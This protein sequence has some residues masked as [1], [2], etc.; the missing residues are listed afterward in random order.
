MTLQQ[1]HNSSCCHQENNDLSNWCSSSIYPP[2]TSSMVV[3]KHMDSLSV[4]PSSQFS[5]QN[6]YYCVDN[7]HPVK[8]Q[9]RFPCSL[10]EDGQ[11]S[12]VADHFSKGSESIDG[13]GENNAAVSMEDT[14]RRMICMSEDNP[15]D[16]FLNGK[17]VGQSKVCARGHWKPA[18]DSKL[19]ELVALYGPQNWNL[20]AEKLQR[21]TGKSCRLRWF[22]QLD[23]RIN[24]KAFTEEEEERLMAAHRAYG[25][26]WAMIARLFPGRTD[27]AVKNHWHVIMARKYREQASAYRR[28]KLSQA[29]Q[30]KLEDNG[31]FDCSGN[32]TNSSNNPYLASSVETNGSYNKTSRKGVAAATSGRDLFLGSKRY[33][34]LSP[35]EGKHQSSLDFFSD[36]RSQEGLISRSSRQW[37]MLRDETTLTTSYPSL[38][39]MQQ[40][41]NHHQLSCFSYSIASSSQVTVTEPSS[42]PSAASTTPSPPPFIDFLGVGA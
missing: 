36:Y 38:M 22:N 4:T 25:N 23:P 27:N 1:F 20:I 40:S 3:L 12:E 24:K 19:R 28:R 34:S 39:L 2:S 6:I 7:Y 10:E 18:E 31:N 41:S 15:G 29:V 30:R 37:N 17:D 32:F 14:R 42:S 35:G 26:K 21:R 16:V 33:S 11:N 5:S 9:M 8:G 13:V